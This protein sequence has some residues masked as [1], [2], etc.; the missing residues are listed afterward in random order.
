MEGKKVIVG[1]SGGVDS[2]VTLWL[3]KSQGLSPIGLTLRFPFWEGSS[4]MRQENICCTVEGIR[5]VK[6]LCLKLGV[7]HFVLDC[8]KEFK[9]IVLEYFVKEY[10]KGKTPN[11]LY[12]LQ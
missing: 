10:K 3:L 7:P 5:W 9:K 8:Q 11:P 1:L 2:S 12:N 6:K 4:S